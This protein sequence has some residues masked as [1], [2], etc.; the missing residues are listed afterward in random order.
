MAGDFH[1]H[2]DVAGVHYYKMLGIRAAGGY[3]RI[4]RLDS[5]TAIRCFQSHCMTRVFLQCRVRR[6]KA[7]NHLKQVGD[8]DSKSL[9]KGGCFSQA[10]GAR[11]ISSPINSVCGCRQCTRALLRAMPGDDWAAQKPFGD[12]AV[13]PDVAAKASILFCRVRS[14]TSSARLQSSV[15]GWS[16]I[17]SRISAR[18]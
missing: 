9:A 2:A 3:G 7:E 12:G 16:G 18:L 5:R 11:K 14:L 10:S 13:L 8:F 1:L 15:F 4:A 17:C 6:G